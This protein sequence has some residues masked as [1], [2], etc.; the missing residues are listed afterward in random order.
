MSTTDRRRPHAGDQDLHRFEH[1]RSAGGR[2][3]GAGADLCRDD[4]AD[5][6]HCEDETTVRANAAAPGRRPRRGRPLPH[7]RSRGGRH[8]H[9]AGDRSGP[10]APASVP[11]AAR[12]DGGRVPLIRDAITRDPADPAVHHGGG[13]PASPVVQRRR[14]R[15]AGDAGADEPVDQDGGR[16]CGAVGGAGW[17]ARFRSSRPTMLRIRWRRSGSRIRN[18]PSGLPAVENSLVADAQRGQRGPTDARTTGAVDVRRAGPRLGHRRQGTDCRGLRRRPR[19]RR[20]GARR[21]RF[22]MR[23][24][25][26]RAAGV[27]WDGVT[28]TRAAGADVGDGAD[29]LRRRK[30][31]RRSS[32]SGSP[33]RSRPGRIL[34]DDWT[35]DDARGTLPSVD[36]A[37]NERDT[38]VHPH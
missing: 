14:L 5:L 38:I 16:Q 30:A 3:G 15:A 34:G 2:A 24:R 31:Q 1:G 11:C 8:R 10:S 12:L 35:A 6:R 26:P 22:A 29:R 33:L 36:F 9:A 17:T 19:A 28:L 7:P 37:P 4:A 21:T 23:S 18:R 25:S 27:P 32:R 13:L 20:P